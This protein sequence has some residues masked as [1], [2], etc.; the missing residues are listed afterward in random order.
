MSAPARRALTHCAWLCAEAVL[1][2]FT[3]ISPGQ[4][5]P[6]KCTPTRNM[7]ASLASPA[8]TSAIRRARHK[9]ASALPSVAS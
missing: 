3:R 8:T 1:R 9:R 4:A 2:P 7:A 6:R 5:P